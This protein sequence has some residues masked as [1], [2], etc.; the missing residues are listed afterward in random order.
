MEMLVDFMMKHSKDFRFMTD[1]ERWEYREQ[2]VEGIKERL[3]DAFAIVVGFAMAILLI[4]LL[5]E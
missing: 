4:I 5:G 3:L 2:A 1:Y